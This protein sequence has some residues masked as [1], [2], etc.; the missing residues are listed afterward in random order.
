[1]MKYI[2]KILLDT[3]KMEKKKKERKKSV[4]RPKGHH[5]WALMLASTQQFSDST[6]LV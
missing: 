5:P 2:S 1:M 3:S 6:A 4:Q